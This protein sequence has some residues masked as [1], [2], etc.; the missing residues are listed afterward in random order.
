[1][2]NGC[3]KLNDI[4]PKVLRAIRGL[5]ATHVWYTGVIEHAHCSDYTRYGIRRDNPAYSQG[6]RPVR[7]MR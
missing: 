7:H 3:G 2:Q 4:T 1:M 5:G 6:A